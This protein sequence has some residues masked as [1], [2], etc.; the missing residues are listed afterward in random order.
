MPDREKEKADGATEV[1]TVLY[2]KESAK[3]SEQAEKDKK[4]AD[5]SRGRAMAA[6][7]GDAG[8]G[9]GESGRD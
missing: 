5:P 4:V 8:E 2:T 1:D 6:L 9:Q 3:S 7:T